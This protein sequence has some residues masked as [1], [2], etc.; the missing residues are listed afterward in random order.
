[1]ISS[2]LDVVFVDCVTIEDEDE[3]GVGVRGKIPLIPLIPLIESGDCVG[4]GVDGGV[5]IEGLLDIPRCLEL[6]AAVFI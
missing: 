4:D 3:D 6:R 2:C 5:D 1:M